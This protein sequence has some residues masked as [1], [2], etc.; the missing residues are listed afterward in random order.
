MG[1]NLALKGRDAFRTPMQWDG[2]PGAGFSKADPRHSSS[3]WS[4]TGAFGYT[5]VN[6]A[7]QRA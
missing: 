1:E 2:R 4:T 3:R 7:A 5:K 6:V